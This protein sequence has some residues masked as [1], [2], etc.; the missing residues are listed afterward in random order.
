MSLGVSQGAAPGWMIRSFDQPMA[1][2]VVNGTH[3]SMG[4]AG[5][6]AAL[7]LLLA[8]CGSSALEGPYGVEPAAVEQGRALA[9]QHCSACHAIGPTG[10]SSFAGAPPLRDI[11]Y[12]YNA[13]SLA[14]ATGRWHGDT[15]GMPPETMSLRDIGYIGAYIRSLRHPRR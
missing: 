3:R 12:D 13:I 8:G 2:R 9:E 1:G 15:A 4:L 7:A 5:A 14:R 11:R 6:A 10:A